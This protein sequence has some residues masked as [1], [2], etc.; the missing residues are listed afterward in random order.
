M[1]TSLHLM[2]L[3]TQSLQ[4]TTDL[5]TQSSLTTTLKCQLT[6]RMIPPS[7]WNAAKTISMLKE[8]FYEHV[9]PET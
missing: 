8:L 7:Q 2:D 5:N 6:I 1:L 3:N 9:I 4:T